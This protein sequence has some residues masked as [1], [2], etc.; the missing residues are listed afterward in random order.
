MI[1]VTT[2]AIIVSPFLSAFINYYI[3]GMGNE[4]FHLEGTLWLPFDANTPVGFFSASL[5]QSMAIY[6][7]LCHANVEEL[8]VD[9]SLKASNGDPDN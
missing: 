1:K 4:S 2:T 7:Q 9:T 8:S 5:F 6:A 3:L